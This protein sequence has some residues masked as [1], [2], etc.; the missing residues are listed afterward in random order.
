MRQRSF[1]AG[2]MGVLFTCWYLIGIPAAFA[3][4]VA[5][6]NKPGCSACMVQADTSNVSWHY[7]SNCIEGSSQ[8]RQAFG[9]LAPC[10]EIIP[11]LPCY[12][13]R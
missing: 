5:G 4:R 6:I 1:N 3:D 2:L 12:P 11:E 7:Q 8:Y 13:R 10:G 9:T